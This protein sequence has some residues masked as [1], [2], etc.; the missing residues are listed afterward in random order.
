M[1]NEVF[2]DTSAI[3]ATLDRDDANGAAAVARMQRLLDPDDPTAGCAVTHGSVVAE[4]AALVQRRLGMEAVRV[5]LQGI[6]PL[7]EVVWVD[8]RLHTRATEAFLAANRRGVSLVDWTSF[9][10]M[11]DRAID[12]SFAFDDDFVDQGFELYSP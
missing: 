7:M 10:V 4:T 1:R 3:F 2:V 11:R 12:V 6:V 9:L 8:E 5:V